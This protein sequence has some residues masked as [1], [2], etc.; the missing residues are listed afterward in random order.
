MSHPRPTP[1]PTIPLALPLIAQ[2]LGVAVEALVAEAPKPKKRAPAP[3]L[4][5]QL[6]RL[7][8]LPKAKQR[9]VIEELDSLQ[10]QSGRRINRRPWKTLGWRNPYEVFAEALTERVAIRN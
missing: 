7:Q 9:L 10:A 5:Q 1:A 4:Q 8:A 2:A 3:K 6:E